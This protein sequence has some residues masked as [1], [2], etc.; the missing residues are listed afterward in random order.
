MD[1]LWAAKVVD[2]IQGLHGKA[3]L[4]TGAPPK[5]R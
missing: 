1:W 2:I 3:Y 4:L 5:P